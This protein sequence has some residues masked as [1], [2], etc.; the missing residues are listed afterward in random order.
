MILHT[1]NSSSASNASRSSHNADTALES[2]E[3]GTTGEAPSHKAP[4]L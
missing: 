2:R 3:Q 4:K 1:E